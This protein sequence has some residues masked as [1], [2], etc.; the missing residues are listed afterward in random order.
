MTRNE[1]LDIGIEMWTYLKEMVTSGQ[2]IGRTKREWFK[3][4]YPDIALVNGCALCDVCQSYENADIMGDS[5]MC[6]YCP[7]VSCY[8]PGSAWTAAWDAWCRQDK[9]AFCAA[10]DT[11]IVAHQEMKK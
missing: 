4:N 5:N 1:K 2:P 7:L 9:E 10:A 3:A 11:I 6:S 8:L